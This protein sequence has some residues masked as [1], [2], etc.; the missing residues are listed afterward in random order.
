M[1]IT[2]FGQVSFPA[3]GFVFQGQSSGSRIPVVKVQVIDSDEDGGG[4]SFAFRAGTK[5]T[6]PPAPALTVQG[7]LHGL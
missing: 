5:R 4:P 1:K 7:L 3:E 2:C 6:R